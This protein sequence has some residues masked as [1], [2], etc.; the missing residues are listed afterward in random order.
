M[1]AEPDLGVR[2]YPFAS[3][4]R[5]AVAILDV[6]SGKWIATLIA[7]EETSTQVEVVFT[8]ALAAEGL[9]D[10]ADAL[11]TDALGTEALRTA[12]ASGEPEQLADLVAAETVPLLLAISDNGPQMRLVLHQGVPRRRRHR[13]AV[14]PPAH[15]DRPGLDRD[16]VRAR[17]GRVAASGV[18]TDPGEVERELDLTRLEY[19]SVT[20]H[21]SIGYVTP[22]DEHNGHGE[23][24]RHAR[25]DGRAR[26]REPA[27]PTVE[28][29]GGKIMITGRPGLGISVI[30]SYIWS[31]TPHTADNGRTP[32]RFLGLPP[33]GRTAV[34]RVLIA[35]R[36]RSQAR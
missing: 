7:A 15:T 1:E 9:L 22:D 16:P 2:L 19:N 24:I 25:R 13:P 18:I 4:K 35:V 17:Q 20:L 10:L 33:V 5:A 36:V 32:R 31:D 14:R 30:N 3:A 21:A 8:D 6:V 27:S 12:L 29:S 26:A 34:A 23:A 11:G 28:T